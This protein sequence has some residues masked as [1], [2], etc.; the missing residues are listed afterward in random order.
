MN[1]LPP[2]YLSEEGANLIAAEIKLYWAQR[3]HAV[4]VEVKRVAGGVV[5]GY[6]PMKPRF[7][8]R[9]NLVNGRPVEA[10]H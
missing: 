4:D 7:E 10:T 3:G 8:V 5:R 2:D 9:S 1:A 6:A